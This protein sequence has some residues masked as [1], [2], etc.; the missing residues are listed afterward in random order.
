VLRTTLIIVNIVA[1]AFVAGLAVAAWVA[2]NRRKEQPPNTTKFYDD[3]TLEGPR[4]E[5]VLGLALFFSAA[6]A[7]LLPLYWLFVP[8]EVHGAFEEQFAEQSIERGAERFTTLG[9]S[10]CHG[11]SGGGGTAPVVLTASDGTPF[12]GQHLAPALNTVLKRFSAEEVFDIITY[13]RPGT[14][15]AGWGIPGNGALNEQT[16]QDLVNFLA[17]IQVTDD[18]ALDTS[19][20]ELEDARATA[21]ERGRTDV[22]DGQLLFEIN[23]ARCHTQ[24][25]STYESYFQDTALDP[26]PALV[27]GGGAFGP[28]LRECSTVRQFPLVADMVEFITNGSDLQRGYGERGIGSGRMPGFGVMLSD[29]QIA[30]IVEYERSL[31]LEGDTCDDVAAAAAAE[32]DEVSAEDDPEAGE[33]ETGEGTADDD[34]QTDDTDAGTDDEG[35]AR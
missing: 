16:V 35:T 33:D 3:E 10:G 34:E 6:V 8:E 28:N 19:E 14:P 5:K 1:V 24:G 17:S 15:M 30:A 32:A 12:P 22:T 13:G 4:L 21:I 18:E 25:F 2:K 9:C 31:G 7:L 20:T 27:M 26:P 23:C 29:D 11:E